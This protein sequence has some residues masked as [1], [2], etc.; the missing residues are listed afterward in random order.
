MSLT[1]HFSILIPRRACNL[2]VSKKSRKRLSYTIAAFGHITEIPFNLPKQ[3]KV[4]QKIFFA[5]TE[6]V[7]IK[8]CKIL[9]Y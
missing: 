5:I 1:L 4:L 9:C 2:S 7:I 8:S 3:I 6:P